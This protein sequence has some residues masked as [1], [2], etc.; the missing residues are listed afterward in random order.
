MSQTITWKLRRVA[1]GGYEGMIVLPTTWGAVAASSGMP[2]AVQSLMAKGKASTPLALK[3]GAQPDAASAID[4]AASLAQ[5]ALN[6]PL[7]RDLLPPGANTALAVAKGV[8]DAVKSG[9][10][11]SAVKALSSGA[12][13]LAKSLKFW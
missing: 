11:G 8:A 9:A 4:K 1:D 12:Q 7:I 2:G 13:S 5:Q 6:N 3:S 10:A